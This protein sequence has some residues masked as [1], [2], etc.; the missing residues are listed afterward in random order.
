MTKTSENKSTVSGTIETSTNHG[1]GQKISN[2]GSDYLVY[3]G[4]EPHSGRDWFAYSD[5]LENDPELLQEYYNAFDEKT[6]S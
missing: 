4:T 5:D 1:R 6:H 2:G 3:V